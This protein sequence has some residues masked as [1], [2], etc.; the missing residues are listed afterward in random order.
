[1]NDKGRRGDVFE[2]IADFMQEV[3][4]NENVGDA[5][6]EPQGVENAL[7]ANVKTPKKQ[8]TSLF[9][10][11]ENCVFNRACPG[12]PA[13]AESSALAMASSSLFVVESLIRFSNA[14][15]SSSRAC[16]FAVI[17]AKWLRAPAP[18]KNILESHHIV[19]ACKQKPV[20]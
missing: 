11:G 17:R 4:S 5:V 3:M 12:N 15:H 18:T 7:A 6:K 13:R 9:C 19:F 2:R 1:M 14:E 16:R 10:R 8:S 20:L